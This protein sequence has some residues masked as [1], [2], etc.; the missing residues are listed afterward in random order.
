MKQSAFGIDNIAF[1]LESLSLLLFF[2]DLK[3]ARVGFAKLNDVQQRILTRVQQ[4]VA[5]YEGCVPTTQLQTR[6]RRM[7]N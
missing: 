6:P 1:G 3:A 5:T 2:G 7:L 4:G